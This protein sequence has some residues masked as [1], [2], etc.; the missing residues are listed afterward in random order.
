MSLAEQE[1]HAIAGKLFLNNQSVVSKD[2]TGNSPYR[3]VAQSIPE[4]SIK[5]PKPELMLQSPPTSPTESADEAGGDVIRASAT[6]PH[7]ESVVSTRSTTPSGPPP[8]SVV[9]AHDMSSMAWRSRSQDSDSEDELQSPQKHDTPTPLSHFN[10]STKDFGMRGASTPGLPNKTPKSV[11]RH[12]ATNSEA[13]TS[14]KSKSRT[15]EKP[16]VS[17]TPLAVQLSSWLA[18]SPEKN[19]P[20]NEVRRPRGIF[21]PVGPTLLSRPDQ[22]LEDSPVMSPIKS[23]F[24]DEMAVRDE[25]NEAESEDR[26]EPGDE[27]QMEIQLSQDSQDS[28]VYGDE[29]AMPLDPKLLGVEPKTQDLTLTCTPAKVFSKQLREIHTVSKVPLRPAAEDTPLKVSRKRSKYLSGTIAA[30]KASQRASSA[31]ILEAQEG[32]TAGTLPNEYLEDEYGTPSRLTLVVPQTPGS[33][34]WSFAGL[35]AM[36]N[37]RG[38]DA[39]ILKGAVVYVDVHTTEGADASGIFLELLTQ[40][41]ARCV[42]QWTWNPRTSFGGSLEGT[43]SGQPASSG[44]G[45][46]TTTTPGSKIGITH[47]VFKDGGKRTLEKVCES[48]GVVLCVGV[49]WVLE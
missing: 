37:R 8:P 48:K 38:A 20:A 2:A 3:L 49:G 36:S 16:V 13:L 25:A 27:N 41:G 19:T 18:A 9:K 30:D 45:H 22:T 10:I 32:T 40:M 26:L 28:E 33:G 15:S 21:S 34:M 17:M 23:T 24:E 5:T 4:S 35:P 43:S 6:E 11:M 47:V 29:N 12:T 42:K 1:E 31:G 39:E 14:T 46:E 7:V 44:S